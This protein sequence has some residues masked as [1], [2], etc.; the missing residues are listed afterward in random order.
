M[1]CQFQY[2]FFPEA[3]CKNISLGIPLSRQI[4]PRQG[5]SNSAWNVWPWQVYSLSQVNRLSLWGLR[6]PLVWRWALVV[7]IFEVDLKLT[8]DFQVAT[9]AQTIGHVSGCHVNPAV[10][11]GLITGAKVSF[12]SLT[13]VSFQTLKQLCSSCSGWSVERPCLHCGAVHWWRPRRRYSY[14]CCACHGNFKFKISFQKLQIRSFESLSLSK[15]VINFRIALSKFVK[16]LRRWHRLGVGITKSLFK[17][18]KSK[19]SGGRRPRKKAPFQFGHCPIIPPSSLV[20]HAIWGKFHFCFPPIYPSQRQNLLPTLEIL[21]KIFQNFGIKFQNFEF[22]LKI[23]KTTEGP[24]LRSK[25]P[26]PPY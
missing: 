1:I 17:A 7:V 20:L 25:G 6:W 21:I 15:A 14:G 16:K 10:T 13:K 5:D 19:V 23:S 4:A 2:H 18:L 24:P 11:A 22:F 9:L 3:N 26:P 12:Q 8:A